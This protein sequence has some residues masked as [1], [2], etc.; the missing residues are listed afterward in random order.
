MTMYWN[1]RIII[2]QI[3]LKKIIRNNWTFCIQ[4]QSV[5]IICYHALFVLS[6]IFSKK[7]LVTSKENYITGEK[8]DH[9]ELFDAVVTFILLI[10]H[11]LS[12][13]HLICE[14]YQ[15]FHNKSNEFRYVIIIIREE[16]RRKNVCCSFVTKRI[17]LK[18][19]MRFWRKN[20]INTWQ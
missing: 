18:Y 8:K 6:F 17:S 3:Y 11:S 1:L 9:H 20:S 2:I 14:I 5:R 12:D 13:S 16:N 10:F 4:I 15:L 7:K 19:M